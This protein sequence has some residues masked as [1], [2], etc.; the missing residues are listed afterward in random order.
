LVYSFQFE[1]VRVACKSKLSYWRGV[2][3]R[4]EGLGKRTSHIAAFDP[5]RVA[6]TKRIAKLLEEML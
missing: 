3:K 4:S 1:N 2:E 6:F 5:S